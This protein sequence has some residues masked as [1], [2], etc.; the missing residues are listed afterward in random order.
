MNSCNV[1]DVIYLKYS[2]RGIQFHQTKKQSS[3]FSLQP[4]ISLDR[5]VLQHLSIYPFIDSKHCYSSFGRIHA[6]FIYY[7]YYIVMSVVYI[8]IHIN[9][10]SCA[11][12]FNCRVDSLCILQRH[13]LPALECVLECLEPSSRSVTGIHSNRC[14]LHKYVSQERNHFFLFIAMHIHYR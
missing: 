14:C 7:L 11:F 9:R 2:L 13:A 3:F 8:W 5:L 10:W 1:F 4:F 12:E 6:S